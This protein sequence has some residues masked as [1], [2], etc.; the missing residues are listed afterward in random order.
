MGAP[1]E[2]G[3]YKKYKDQGLLI[4]NVF[5]GSKD[6]DIKEFAET[7]HLTFPVGGDNGMMET[8]NVTGIPVTFFIGKDGEITKQVN[9]TIGYK[10][11]HGGIRELLR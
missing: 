3:A 5:V 9:G 2:E 1:V 7:F 10:A 11:L 4:L 8:F 6:K